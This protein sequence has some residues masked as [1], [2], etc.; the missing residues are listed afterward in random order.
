MIIFSA[1]LILFVLI[2]SVSAAKDNT[3]TLTQDT[4]KEINQEKITTGSDE[5]SLNKEILKT[6][7]KNTTLKEPVSGRTFNDIQTAINNAADGE[8]VELSGL[9]TGDGTVITL[10]KTLTIIGTNDATLDAKGKSAIFY[11]TKEKTTLKNIKFI[12]G[13]S[14][15]GGAIEYWQVMYSDESSIINCTF[16]NNTANEGGAIGK[17]CAYCPHL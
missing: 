17:R 15:I 9:Y 1:F 3:T 10:N 14:N 8:T 16:I 4:T 12:N 13:N 5:S 11:I 6:N 2:G 7:N